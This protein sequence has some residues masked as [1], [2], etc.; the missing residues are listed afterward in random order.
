MAGQGRP[1]VGERRSGAPT[2][3]TGRAFWA[4]G[5]SLWRPC[6]R[7][8]C[9]RPAKRRGEGRRD[10][11]RGEVKGS[12]APTT[13]GGGTPHHCYIRPRQGSQVPSMSGSSGGCGGG[14]DGRHGRK[15]QR[16]LGGG[17]R[18]LWWQARVGHAIG[19]VVVGGGVGGGGERHPPGARQT[20][21]VSLW[22][23]ASLPLY[24]M[25]EG[26]VDGG[27][28]G[29]GAATPPPSPVHHLPAPPPSPCDCLPT[30]RPAAAL[31][32]GTARRLGLPGSHGRQAVSPLPMGV[33]TSP[34]LR[35]FAGAAVVVV[36]TVLF[37]DLRTGV[38]GTAGVATRPSTAASP[39]FS[40][41]LPVSTAARVG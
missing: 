40:V 11:H 10:D 34:P 8:W 17:Q 14:D 7:G 18:R 41:S 1:G 31:F 23:P 16:V 19:A 20:R 32:P 30:P 35:R 5:G 24:D 6:G 13:P 38:V 21:A 27:A 12:C 36:V 15:H 29:G 28:L 3:L 9:G 25:G 39:A 37:L 4:S 22:R 26:G 33:S 2:S